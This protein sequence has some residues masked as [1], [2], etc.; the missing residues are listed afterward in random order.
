MF[1]YCEHNSGFD[2]ATNDNDTILKNFVVKLNNSPIH[3]RTI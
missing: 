2:N 1:S 3:G